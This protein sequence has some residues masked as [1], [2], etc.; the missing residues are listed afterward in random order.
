MFFKMNRSQGEEGKC[1]LPM[2]KE[3]LILS[4]HITIKTVVN[5]N[6]NNKK[7]PGVVGPG[8]FYLEVERCQILYRLTALQA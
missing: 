8:I 5:N 7:L 3:V 4:P 2:K 6:K 1:G